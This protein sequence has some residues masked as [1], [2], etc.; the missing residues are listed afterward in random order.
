M[1]YVNRSNGSNRNSVLI[2]SPIAGKSLHNAGWMVYASENRTLCLFSRLQ[3][4]RKE[5]PARLYFLVVTLS[6]EGTKQ[7]EF[8]FSACLKCLLNF[9]TEV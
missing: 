8:C 7:S 5:L 3:L 9:M 4:A 1:M 2:K 6:L